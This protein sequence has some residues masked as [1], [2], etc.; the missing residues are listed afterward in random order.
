M[1]GMSTNGG[2]AEIKLT[3]TSGCCEISRSDHTLNLLLS[4]TSLMRKS[5][6]AGDSNWFYTHTPKTCKTLKRFLFQKV[7]QKF[8]PSFV[9]AIIS[10]STDMTKEHGHEL[11]K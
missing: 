9:L 11:L 10:Y 2:Q 3:D 4:Q 1:V 8:N 7:R 6:K 5:L